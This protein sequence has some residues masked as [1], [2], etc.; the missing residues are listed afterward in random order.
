[1]PKM[2]GTVCDQLRPIL[3]V[4]V[5]GGSFPA[6]VDT[7]FEGFL[8]VPASE[9]PRLRAMRTSR[10]AR[11][12]VA[13]GSPPFFPLGRMRIEW[14][15]SETTVDVHLLN[16]PEDQLE[17]DAQTG[18]PLCL[19]GIYVL[20]AVHVSIDFRPGGDVLLESP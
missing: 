5:P 18:Q 13:D 14:F 12:T 17:V 15:G 6:W 3:R 19:I 10:V 4:N 8:Q 2:V 16:V 20:Q 1:M 11:M 7:A 9:G